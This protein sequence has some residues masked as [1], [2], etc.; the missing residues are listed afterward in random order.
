MVVVVVVITSESL[1]S[2]RSVET[3]VFGV[4]D[5]V[6]GDEVDDLVVVDEELVEFI[7][8]VE[9]VLDVDELDEV[10]RVRDR[11]VAARLLARR[12]LE[13]EW[14]KYSRQDNNATKSGLSQSGLL[15]VEASSH[16]TFHSSEK[17][18]STTGPKKVPDV[19]RCLHL[20]VE[21][22]KGVEKRLS[23]GVAVCWRGKRFPYS[24]TT[25]FVATSSIKVLL[26]AVVDITEAAAL[27]G[28]PATPLPLHALCPHQTTHPLQR[29]LMQAAS[30]DGEVTTVGAIMGGPD[31]NHNNDGDDCEATTTTTVQRGDSDDD[32]DGT[33]GDSSDDDKG[34]E[35]ADG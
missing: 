4:E 33:R 29:V 5:E 9:V 17:T 25:P 11:G 23:H 30:D 1:Q 7:E 2:Q 19:A 10:C 12:G 22:G 34:V 20:C 15:A 16:R 18:A 27:R 24:S 8:L 21:R 26:P 32:N 3:G 28:P 35:Q 6:G 14:R 13:T 31:S